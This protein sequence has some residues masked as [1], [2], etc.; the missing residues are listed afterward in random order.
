M[1]IICVEINRGSLTVREAFRNLGEMIET[2]ESE[3]D[4]DH[5]WEVSN[6]L[7]DLE[8]PMED[9]DKQLNRERYEMEADDNS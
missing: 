1:C 6:R 4:K 8:V 3:E 9:L 5:L 2:A 7:L